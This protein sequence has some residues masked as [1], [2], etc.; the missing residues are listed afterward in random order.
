MSFGQGITNPSFFE[1]FGFIPSTFIGNPELQPERSSSYDLG[2]AQSWEGEL[3]GSS[4]RWDFD[5]TYFS[6][7]LQNEI[8]TVYDA[9]FMSRP[10]NLETDSDRS[11]IEVSGNVVIA[12]AW[13]VA[14]A[15]TRLTAEE[16]GIEEVRRPKHS[17]QLRI[18][19]D[20]A[21]SKGRA[22]IQ[23][24]HNGQRTDNEFIYA[25][26]A[27]RVNLQPYTLT[28][29]GISYDLRPNLTLTG[30]IDNL[31]DTQYQEV[32]GYNSP[33]RY[34]SVGAKLNLE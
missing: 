20:F 4:A 28:N 9:N 30:R 1:L 33:G 26:A 14:V 16:N 18:S 31:A 12:T 25:T 27:T 7:D 13:Q 24:L 19:R 22:S 10:I 21:D 15:Y 2:W 32:F 34:V 5:L 8:T 17:G 6:A 23:F 3:A 29:I 11:G